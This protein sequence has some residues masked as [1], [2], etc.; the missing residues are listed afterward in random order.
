MP[1]PQRLVKGQ[2]RKAE[3]LWY[4]GTQI[5]SSTYW[6]SPGALYWE[7]LSQLDIGLC[8]MPRQI[9]SRGM[10]SQRTRLVHQGLSDPKSVLCGP[11]FWFPQV[12][13]PCEEPCVY[14]LAVSIRTGSATLISFCLK[15]FQQGLVFNQSSLPSFLNYFLQA[16]AGGSIWWKVSLCLGNG[17][18]S[19]LF[20]KLFK[21]C[22]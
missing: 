13:E 5:W 10:D 1:Q 7:P 8:L 9:A 6:C 11:S 17:G 4:C 19:D 20:K 14:F 12:V 18:T 21:P 16:L 3:R 22:G 15:G 2:Q